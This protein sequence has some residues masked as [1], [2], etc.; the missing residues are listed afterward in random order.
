MTEPIEHHHGSEVLDEL[1]PLGRQL[2]NYV[3]E[4]YRAHAEMSRAA[5][6][7]GALE[8][9]TKELMALAI[10]VAVRCDGCIASHAKG[11][12]LAG[13]TRE[14]AAEAIGVAVLMSGG[15][16]TVYGPRAFDAFCEFARDK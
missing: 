7:P 6:G 15:P 3:P 11:A 10:G 14:E 5:L 13:A 9:K 1:S 4:V 2:R 12:A 16:G 8:T